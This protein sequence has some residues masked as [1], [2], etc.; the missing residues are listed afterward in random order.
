MKDLINS[1]NLEHDFVEIEPVGSEPE[2]YYKCL[3]QE[4]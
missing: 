1:E 4:L 3:F 2:T